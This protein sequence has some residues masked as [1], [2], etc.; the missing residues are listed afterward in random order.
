MNGEFCKKD[1]VRPIYQ[2]IQRLIKQI[3]AGKAG[4]TSLVTAD[5]SI[6][7]EI[8]YLGGIVIVRNTF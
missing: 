8:E 2:L 5:S 1:I 6:F 7:I 4:L 3:K